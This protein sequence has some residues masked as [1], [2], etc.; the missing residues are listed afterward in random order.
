MPLEGRP[1]APQG[2][3]GA[4][5]ARPGQ[6][7][8][9]LGSRGRPWAPPWSP[10]PAQPS[11]ASS[12]PINHPRREAASLAAQIDF[13]IILGSPMEGPKNAHVGTRWPQFSR[14]FHGTV[15]KK[16]RKSKIMAAPLF[17][18]I[19][20]K[21]IYYSLASAE[22][23]FFLAHTPTQILEAFSAEASK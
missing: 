6:G 12:S 18:P 19:L 13:S 8:A 17:G 10:W 22:V 11:P 1:W 9:R 20:G 7:W 23:L 3:S 15:D 16:I 14:R 4:P 5:L 2:H 21:H